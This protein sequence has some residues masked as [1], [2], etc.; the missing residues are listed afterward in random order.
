MIQKPVMLGKRAPLPCDREPCNTSTDHAILTGQRERINETQKV[1]S[2]PE[3]G[4]ALLSNL[5]FPTKF[6]LH[7]H[8]Y[9]RNT[10]THITEAYTHTTEIHTHHRNK[11][12]PQKYIHTPQKYTHTT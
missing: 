11:H 6:I 8:T 10:H 9:H 1:F 5:H 12:T 7:T 4:D 3:T 2:Y